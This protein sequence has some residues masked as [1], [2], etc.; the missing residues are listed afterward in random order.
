MGRTWLRALIS[1]ALMLFLLYYLVDPRQAGRILARAHWG[2]LAWLAG[3]ITLDRLLMTYKWRLLLTCRGLELGFW[4][5]L[6][7]YYLASFA[8]CFLPS[9]LGADALRIMAVKGPRR[10][11]EVVAASV[12]IERTLGFLAAVIAA[13]L[14]LCL[15]T[16]LTISLP[17]AFLAWSLG[18][19]GLLAAGVVF[20]LSSRFGRFLHWLEVR[21]EA[22]GRVGSWLGKALMAYHGYR[23]HGPALLWFLLLSVLEQSGPVVGTWLAALAFDIDLG[24]L[25]AAAVAPVALLFTRVPVSVSGFGVVEGLYVAL[26]S[27]VGLGATDAFVLG[28]IANISVVV[29]TLPGAVFYLRSGLNQAGD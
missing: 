21:L 9:T 2:Y 5:A 15:L 19:G 4:P 14:G 8:G 12:V 24:L 26:F 20:S 18:L 22:W 1:G 25:A 16:W 28:F 11:G 13:L 7:A 10:P 6:K 29:T 17:P 23:D 27:L 3:W